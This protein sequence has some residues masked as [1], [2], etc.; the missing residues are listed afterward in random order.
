M[1]VAILCEYILPETGAAV[2]RMIHFAKYFERF[3]VTTTIFAP[4]RQ[5]VSSFRLSPGVE[6]IRYT[7]IRHLFSLLKHAKVQLILASSPA[8]KYPFFASIIAKILRIPCV[9]DVRDPPSYAMRYGLKVNPFSYQYI[10]TFLLEFIAYHLT[11]EIFIVTK[12]Q[13]MLLT[14]MFH[15]PHSKFSIVING[16]EREIAYRDENLR[17][18]TRA[19]LNLPD[20]ANLL[21]FNGALGGYNFI[22]MLN[23]IGDRIFADPRCYLLIISGLKWNRQPL[24]EIKQ[25]FASKP[26]QKHFILMDSIP[27]NEMA[28]YLSAADIGLLPLIYEWDYTIPVKSY[29]FMLAEL[30]LAIYGSPRMP[31]FR[32]AKSGHYGIIASDWEAFFAGLKELVNNIELRKRMGMSGKILA[33]KYLLRDYAAQVALRRLKIIAKS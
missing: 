5:G 24:R 26:Y 32:M 9:A 12:Y 22:A 14:R 10:K 20:D 31:L 2:N 18:Q 21:F 4:M 13:R 29:E 28:K 11:T 25:F 6:I 3:G 1:K 30:P 27:P 8:P 19:Q 23:A 15:V 33:E 17:K 16:G 7:S